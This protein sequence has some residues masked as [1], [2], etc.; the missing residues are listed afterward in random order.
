MRIS[1]SLVRHIGIFLFVAAGVARPTAAQSLTSGALRGVVLYATDGSPIA[2]VQVTVEG[3]D[4]RPIRFLES[5][6]AGQFSVPLLAPGAY[7]ILAEQVGLQPVRLLGVMVAGGQ[8]TAVTFRLERRPPPVESVVELDQSGAIAGTALGRTVM[9]SWLTASDRHPAATDASRGL[10]E[11]DGPRDVREGFA[12]SGGGLGASSARLVVDGLNEALVRHPGLAGEPASAPLFSR[13]ALA[14]AQVLSMGLDTEWRGLPGATLNA[15][16]ARGGNAVSL[17]PYGSLSSATLGAD[18]NDNPADST[19]ASFQV[20]A[21]L[22]GPIVRDTAYFMLR[23]DF[24]QLRTPSAWPWEQDEAVYNGQAVSLRET[25]PMV[26]QDQFGVAALQAAAPTVRTWQG[27]TGLGRIDW[28]LGNNGVFFRF[29]YGKWKEESPLLLDERSNLSGVELDATDLSGA[30]GVTSEFGSAANEFRIGFT[31]AKREWTGA[32]LPAT[33][34]AA[35]GVAFGNSAALPA[36]FDQRSIEFSNALQITAGQHRVKLG[37]GATVLEHK[38]DYRYGA[39]GVFTFGSLDGFAQGEGTFYQTVGPSEVLNP[40]VNEF[41]V[42]VQDLWTVSPEFSFLL[43]VRWDRQQLPDDK[44]LLD[45]GWLDHTGQRN[46]FVPTASGVSPRVGFTWDVQNRG[47]WIVR[48][49]AGLFQGRLDPALFSEAASFDGGVTVRRGQGTFAAWP[50]LPDNTQAPDLGARLTFFNS[51]YKLPRTFKGGISISRIM[52]GGLGLHLSGSY[53]H[54]DYLLRRTELNLVPAAVGETQEGRPVYGTLVQQGGL[55][56]AAP[57]TN[58]RFQDYDQVHGLSPTG[59]ADYYEF[60]ALLERRVAQGLSAA[61]SYTFSTTTDNVP[62]SMAMDP[63]DQLNP[64]PDGLNGADWSDG[65]SDFDVPHRVAA[66]AEY[67]SGGRT[68]VTLGARWRYRSGLPFTPGF[69]PGVDLNG[70]GA[71]NNDPAYL[72]AGISGL[73]AALAGADCDIATNVFAVRNSC[74]AEAAHG[75]DLRLAVGLPIVARDGSRLS[76][77]VDAFNVVSSAVGIV[78]R[79]LVLVDPNGALAVDGQGNVSVPLVANPDFGKL[80]SRR[81]DPRLIRV[82]LRMEY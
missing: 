42:F 4:G 26:A 7:R 8:V 68:P 57:G 60:T 45:D 74:R 47:D 38:Q 53:H 18:A 24:Q 25:L 82:G 78:D 46:D 40:R 66:S 17:R 79:A 81:N 37:G 65:T 11:V 12:V 30:L 28:R 72:D 49:G 23:F 2:G 77:T 3:P 44:I 52:A 20:G 63:A 76:L 80:S 14:Q 67:R 48:G 10:T 43:G 69:R 62:G 33:S 16:T 61:V 9:G 6:R 59:Y 56:T 51:T 36:M 39:A 64:F 34:L 70:D 50:S 31:S 15:H 29:G 58:R 19:G 71:G 22:S 13:G 75:L 27:A 32:A 41:G 35:E 5:D 55:V 73:Q 21:T 54:T 1:S